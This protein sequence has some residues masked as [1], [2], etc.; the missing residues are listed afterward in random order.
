MFLLN[1]DQFQYI[2]AECRSHPVRK[3]LIIR[4]NQ[5]ILMSHVIDL[6]MRIRRVNPLQAGSVI[7]K[8]SPCVC[9]D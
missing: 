6:L 1:T 4:S 8:V 7:G 2:V 3:E 5:K 9:S